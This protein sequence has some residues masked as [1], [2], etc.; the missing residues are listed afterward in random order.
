MAKAGGLKLDGRLLVLTSAVWV[1]GLLVVVF[2]ISANR[3][4]QSGNKL[5][6][7]G[8]LGFLFK[9]INPYLFA[10]FGIAF[11]IGLSVL[12]AAWCV[13]PEPERAPRVSPIPPPRHTNPKRDSL[14]I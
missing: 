11:A 4:E 8:Y 1:A 6:D 10:A 5:I 13:P 2:G 14:V 7:F 3:A 9:R 12:G